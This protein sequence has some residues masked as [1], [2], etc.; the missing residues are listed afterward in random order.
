MGP[1]LAL[2][3]RE[4]SRAARAEGEA[5]ALV[6]AGGLPQAGHAAAS[7]LGTLEDRHDHAA[8]LDVRRRALGP[9]P[10][11]VPGVEHDRQFDPVLRRPPRQLC[12]MGRSR[13]GN[14]AI[15]AAVAPLIRDR[16][17]DG[18][19][20]TPAQ[21]VIGHLRAAQDGEAESRSRCVVAAG[22]FRDAGEAP[23]RR[24]V[25]EVD[26]VDHGLFVARARALDRSVGG[27]GDAHRLTQRD[28]D[29]ELQHPMGLVPID[30][31][32]DLD[33]GLAL[34]E[35]DVLHHR[36]PPG[37]ERPGAAHGGADGT[38]FD[39]PDR[40]EVPLLLVAPV[41]IHAVGPGVTVV[42]DD[43][44]A[45]APGEQ[46]APAGQAHAV[47]HQLDHPARV[48]VHVHPHE[49]VGQDAVVGG[50]R[51]FHRGR[52]D[53]ARR[54][55]HVEP[56]PAVAEG[57]DGRAEEAAR[58]AVRHLAG[59]DLLHPHA[60]PAR[61]G[62]RGNGV[63]DG[64]RTGRRPR[65]RVE[66]DHGQREPTDRALHALC[67]LGPFDPR[68]DVFHDAVHGLHR[69]PFRPGRAR[70]EECVDRLGGPVGAGAA[71]GVV[72]LG[73][74]D[75]LPRLGQLAA[76]VGSV[77]GE[78]AAHLAQDLR[79]DQCVLG[80][81][82]G[83]LQVGAGR[84]TPDGMPLELPGHRGQRVGPLGCVLERTEVAGGDRRSRW[85][86]RAHLAERGRSAWRAAVGPPPWSPTPKKAMRGIP[87]AAP[88]S[89]SP[90]VR[91]RITSSSCPPLVE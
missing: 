16:V 19:V 65:M 10:P 72:E 31:E 78:Q 32:T 71:E 12:C 84:V 80:V 9:E 22:R 18:V 59:G 69:H 46:S 5:D 27:A 45:H 79:R 25:G 43:H 70:D 30:V 26:P 74:E 60:L 91:L 47:R 41:A 51:R 28:G 64:D 3:D 67:R 52:C 33:R 36:G 56:V 15:P 6:P 17:A 58:R 85:L 81:P 29:D 62:R 49:S 37:S 42:G 11:P 82:V 24:G 76:D 77:A 44:R 20:G 50:A 57:R 90:P 83:E 88:C 53:A 8:G 86:R 34:G 35:A 38:G 66:D 48:H 13:V 23:P 55:D 61:V 21:P 2:P 73:E 87:S 14:E 75:A 89:R 39:H 7:V 68:V 63:G 4:E 40:E 54:I 1:Q